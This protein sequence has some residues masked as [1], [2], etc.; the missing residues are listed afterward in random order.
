[1]IVNHHIAP[2][3][4]FQLVVDLLVSAQ[5]EI[6]KGYS[7]GGQIITVQ[8]SFAIHANNIAMGGNVKRNGYM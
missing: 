3:A 5:K 4:L 2:N 7:F 1:M 8:P 6:P